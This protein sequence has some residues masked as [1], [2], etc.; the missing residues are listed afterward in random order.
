[1]ASYREL[2]GALRAIV[3]QIKV[4]NPPPRTGSLVNNADRLLAEAAIGNI[5]PT[6]WTPFVRAF[7]NPG[8]A[9]NVERM[10]RALGKSVSDTREALKAE[11]DGM[12]LWVNSRYQ[13]QVRR[14]T[15]GRVWLSVKRL[16]QG[17][18][19]SWRDKQRIKNELCGPEWE[20]VELFP[21]ESRLVDT[22]NQYHLWCTE[23]RFPLGFNTRMISVETDIGEGQEPFELDPFELPEE[24]SDAQH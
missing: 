4:G 5:K 13:V 22:A 24:V 6:A 2:V 1:M 11:M 16:D 8:S 17:V 10:A 19:D 12:D 9:E 3:R 7:P 23:N 18:I 20:A 14:Y 15:S 21:A